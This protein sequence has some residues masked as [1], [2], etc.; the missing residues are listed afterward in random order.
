MSLKDC[1]RPYNKIRIEK[2]IILQST[3][4]IL[5]ICSNNDTLIFRFADYNRKDKIQNLSTRLGNIENLIK[6]IE[7]PIIRPDIMNQP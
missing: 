3:N 1:Q 2:N 6:S 4:F 5:T 7:S